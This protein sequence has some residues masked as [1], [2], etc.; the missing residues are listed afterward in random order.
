MKRSLLL[1]LILSLAL[2]ACMPAFL[3]QALNPTPTVNAAATSAALEAA[4]SAQALQSQP[5]AS[6]IPS[7]TPVVASP[8][9]T[10]APTSTRVNTL[11]PASTP[12]AS[13]TPAPL[14]PSLTPTLGV[15]FFGTLPPLVPSGRMTMINRSHAQAYVSFQCTNKEGTLS[16]MEYPVGRWSEVKIA[17]GKCLYVAWVGGRQFDGSFTLD[18]GGS[19]RIVFFK[20]RV[21]IK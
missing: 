21:T 18:P 11:I 4:T 1:A 16:V 20:D 5:T 17:A 8:T 15:M 14:T 3:Q 9:N 19:K 2:N 12:T 13:F 7:S 10:T 6:P